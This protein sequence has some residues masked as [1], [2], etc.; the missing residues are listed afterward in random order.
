MKT[1]AYISG[2]A[3]GA[4]LINPENAIYING[5]NGSEIILDQHFFSHLLALDPEFKEIPFDG[6]GALF[7]ELFIE[8]NRQ[9]A[10]GEALEIMDSRLSFEYRKK[11]V[12]YLNRRIMVFSGLIDFLINRLYST[13]LPDMFDPKLAEAVLEGQSE[14]L[15][16]LFKDL[17]EKSTLF[18]KFYT[19]FRL[20]L[21][22]ETE[23]Q[24]KIDVILSENGS[25][26][27]FTMALYERS[28]NFYN[29]GINLSVTALKSL[30]PSVTKE[31]FQRIGC[32]LKEQYGL[33]LNPLEINFNSGHYV[34]LEPYRFFGSSLKTIHHYFNNH[35]CVSS[36]QIQDLMFNNL[37]FVR[38]KEESKS[39]FEVR[40]Y[41]QVLNETMFLKENGPHL[42]LAK[43]RYKNPE[44]SLWRDKLELLKA[45][46]HYLHLN[47]GDSLIENL[48]FDL[49]Y[50]DTHFINQKYQTA[51]PIYFSLLAR[52]GYSATLPSSKPLLAIYMNIGIKLAL[53]YQ[54]LGRKDDAAKVYENVQNCMIMASERNV[55]VGR[56]LSTTT[57]CNLKNS[58]GQTP[59][60][61]L[62]LD[63]MITVISKCFINVDDI[64][65]LTF[66]KRPASGYSIE[67]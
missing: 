53:S 5:E 13:H 42:G 52:T 47:Q 24:S 44:T 65:T 33:S 38:L 25:F 50:A 57:D 19:I 59:G 43:T 45:K 6:R 51:V 9:E 54:M 56:C 7:E 16:F 20:A 26:A 30:Y 17:G 32:S 60:V 18:S 15:A 64:T 1:T 41:D 23:T 40:L 63:T 55:A 2:N 21:N 48:C 22:E 8:R 4:I 29:Y 61:E 28:L 3:N 62:V 35:I 14:Q 39:Q 10:L 67:K 31:L 58:D 66:V 12:H 34:N 27:S 46:S 11:I 36:E 49:L 37:P